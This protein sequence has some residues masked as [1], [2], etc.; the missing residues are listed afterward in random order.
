[1]YLIECLNN[2]R[3][4][5]CTKLINKRNKYK[6]EFSTPLEDVAMIHIEDDNIVELTN[7][8]ETYAI[9]YYDSLEDDWG[10]E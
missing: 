4:K 2:E 6:L 7:K 1:M 9:N 8:K 3:I 5:E 10:I